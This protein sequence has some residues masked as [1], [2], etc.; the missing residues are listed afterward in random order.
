MTGIGVVVATYEWPAA[1]DAVLFG[2][3]EQTDPD[4]DVV[5]ADDGSGPETAAVVERWHEAFGERL[6]YARQD[7][8]GFRL[9]RVKNLG[10][11]EA[12]GDFLV[13]IDGDAV[14]RRGFVESMRRAAT[15]GW[16]VAGKR[17]ELD[18]PLTDRVLSERLPIQRWSLARWAL[19]AVARLPARGAD[20][21]RPAAARSSGPARVRSARQPLRV[22]ARRLALGLRARQRPRPALRRLGRGGRRPRR[23]PTPPPA[24]LWLARAAGDAPPPVARDAE[25]RATERRA[26]RGDAFR[27]SRRGRL[28]PAR[29]LA[30]G[31]ARRARRGSGPLT[32]HARRR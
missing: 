32:V 30:D 31:V 7:D 27:R 15:Q 5:V 11:V 12:R 16:F 19:R 2:L 29:A 22:A 13:M 8:Q 6:R 23:P 14:P 24:A 9:A 1:L 10:A 26:A 3:S 28:R 20:R 18:E 4:F 17:L 25:G 21:A